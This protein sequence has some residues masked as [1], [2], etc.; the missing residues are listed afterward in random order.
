MVV[1]DDLQSL[2]FEVSCLNFIFE[3]TII[4]WKH[5]LNIQSTIF[6]YTNIYASYSH[7]FQRISLLIVLQNNIILSNNIMLSAFIIKCRRLTIMVSDEHIKTMTA[8]ILVL[9]LVMSTE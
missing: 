9:V 2:N 1:F 8:L 7:I 5:L 6:N 3:H 4:F